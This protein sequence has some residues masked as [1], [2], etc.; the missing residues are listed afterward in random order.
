LLSAFPFE[1]N[2]FIQSCE[3][4]INSYGA[5]EL[6]EKPSDIVDKHIDDLIQVGRRRWDVGFFIIDKDPI[7]DVEGSS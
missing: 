2:K 7:Y 1:E 3:E 4:V 5:D 6:V